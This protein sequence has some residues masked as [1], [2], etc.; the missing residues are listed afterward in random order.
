M[1]DD[2]QKTHEDADALR[3]RSRVL[4]IREG[5]MKVLEADPDLSKLMLRGADYQ[6]HIRL[7]VYELHELMVQ[8]VEADR[9][10]RLS[11]ENLLSAANDA[12][13]EY[14]IALPAHSEDMR[15][16]IEAAIRNATGA[17]P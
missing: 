5:A 3:E 4:G 12:F 11:E 15:P 10:A 2:V 14:G 13:D 1:A 8:A 16:I 7:G 9:A 6:A 17:K